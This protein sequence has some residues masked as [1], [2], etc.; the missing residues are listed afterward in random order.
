VRK[1][2]T[3]EIF[4]HTADLGLRVRAESFEGLCEEAARGLTEVIAGD[5]G[6]IRPVLGETITV[7]GVE[8]VWLLFDLRRM[9]FAECRVVRTSDGIRTDCRGERF[10]PAWHQLAHVVKAIT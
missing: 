3:H 7:P 2:A 6:M 1:P 5:P 4:D 8:P 10:D 9:L